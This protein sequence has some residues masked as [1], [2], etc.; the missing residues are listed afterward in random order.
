M[1]FY[2]HLWNLDY[3]DKG[4]MRNLCLVLIRH[5]NRVKIGY[6]L[7]SYFLSLFEIEI[8]FFPCECLCILDFLG[9]KYSIY[10]AD[11]ESLQ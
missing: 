2:F 4:K 6:F 3:S 11:N 5:I 10:Y 7:H 8:A 1:T 9:I